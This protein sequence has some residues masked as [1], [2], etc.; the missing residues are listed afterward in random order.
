MGAT[1]ALAVFF[2]FVELVDE[3]LRVAPELEQHQTPDVVVSVDL[4]VAAVGAQ[5]EAAH[6]GVDVIVAQL[7]HVADDL[8]DERL[9]ER[10][11][12]LAFFFG[13]FC[14]VFGFVCVHGRGHFDFFG[15]FAFFEGQ[16][17]RQRYCHEL[18]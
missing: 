17:H 2:E 5:H 3:R 8:D 12:D 7:L 9:F 10:P 15:P 11:V 1:A 14:V 13:L 6:L 4:G 18:N 16:Q